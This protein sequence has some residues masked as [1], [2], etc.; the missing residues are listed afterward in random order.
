MQHVIA[1]IA[2]AHQ[3]ILAFDNEH[4]ELK[5]LPYIVIPTE[6]DRLIEFPS[7]TAIYRPPCCGLES[8]GAQGRMDVL[9]EGGNGMARLSVL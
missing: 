6:M 1:T 8:P 9:I 7:G 2:L 3:T 5:I 4:L